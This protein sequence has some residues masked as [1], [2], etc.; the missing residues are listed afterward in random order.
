MIY[1]NLTLSQMMLCKFLQIR[2]DDIDDNNF[3]IQAP[4]ERAKS[5]L[6]LAAVTKPNLNIA[7]PQESFKPVWNVQKLDATLLD[8]ARKKNAACVARV[9]RIPAPRRIPFTKQCETVV[10]SGMLVR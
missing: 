2:H 9:G 8:C 6:C 5:A 7:R 3:A 10:S 4:Q 1:L